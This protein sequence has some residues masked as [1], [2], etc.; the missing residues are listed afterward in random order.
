MPELH[1]AVSAPAMYP[2]HIHPKPDTPPPLQPPPLP[3]PPL[4]PHTHTHT[5]VAAAPELH[6]AAGPATSHVQP[7]HVVI[8][9]NPWPPSTPPAT[10]THRSGGCA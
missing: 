9:L 4:P 7:S 6:A 2:W 10:H 5:G 1:A 3:L 8:H